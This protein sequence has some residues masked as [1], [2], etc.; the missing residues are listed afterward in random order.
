MIRRECGRVHKGG[1][2][3]S[4]ENLRGFEEVETHGQEKI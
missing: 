4:G 2:P 1:D 3:W